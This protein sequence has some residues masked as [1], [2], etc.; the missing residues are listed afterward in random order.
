MD[1]DNEQ[2][3]E[4]LAQAYQIVFGG[5]MP[6]IHQQ[7]VRADLERFCRPHAP[8]YSETDRETCLREGRREVWLRMFDSIRD[9]EPTLGELFSQLFTSDPFTHDEDT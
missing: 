8:T 3:I 2:R 1:V 4:A 5:K 9:K 7:L 6:N